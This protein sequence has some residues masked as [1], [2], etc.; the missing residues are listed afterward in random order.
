MQDDSQKKKNGTLTAKR[1]YT[2]RKNIEESPSTSKNKLKKPLGR[3]PKPKELTEIEKDLLIIKSATT[4][5]SN[6][7]S[8]RQSV[9]EKQE[10]LKNKV[11]SNSAEEII[12]SKGNEPSAVLKKE[13]DNSTKDVINS[14]DMESRKE[15]TS[16]LDTNPMEE[17]LNSNVKAS[18]KELQKKLDFNTI[19]EVTLSSTEPSKGPNKPV[20]RKLDSKSTNEIQISNG[21]KPR[22]GLKRKLFSLSTEEVSLTSTEPSVKRQKCD[23]EIEVGD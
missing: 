6:E 15:E 11:N 16:K 13:L 17:V 22:K 19:E 23:E 20:N 4:V 9:E 10:P 2:K 14:N 7:S 18:S 3:P 21:T 12:I 1:K 8:R 5:S